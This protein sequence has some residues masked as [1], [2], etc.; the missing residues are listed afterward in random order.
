MGGNKRK[1][2]GI[3]WRNASQW[4]TF[5]VLTS[6]FLGNFI[7]WL[8]MKFKLPTKERM[9]HW[10]FNGESACTLCRAFTENK[11]HL[12]F[13]SS[14]TRRIWE[15]YGTL[16]HLG[17]QVQLSGFGT[18]GRQS[19]WRKIFECI[20]KLA[21][22]GCSVPPMEPKKPYY[23]CR[24]NQNRWAVHQRYQEGCKGKSRESKK[25]KAD[26]V[27]NNFYAAP[28]VSV[29]CK[30]RQIV[31]ESGL[32]RLHPVVSLVFFVV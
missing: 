13:H 8:A 31:I 14:F 12:F 4:S 19:S 10:E 25:W 21:W 11:Y 22:W 6:P 9:L 1:G 26:T 16:F 32:S 18:L 30:S 17:W 29:I 23:S 24:D 3:S 2:R 28:G 7:G 20:C 27:L 5:S 15:T